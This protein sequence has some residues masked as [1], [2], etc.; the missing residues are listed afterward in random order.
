V[1]DLI[2]IF[3]L[4]VKIFIPN[5]QN[6]CIIYMYLLNFNKQIYNKYQI[7]AIITS[8]LYSSTSLSDCSASA[9]ISVDSLCQSCLK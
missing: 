8:A 5:F 6:K 1:V 3:V 7:N 9:G 4:F 2:N